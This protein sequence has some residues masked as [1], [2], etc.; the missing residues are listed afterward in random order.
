MES[1]QTVS[2]KQTSVIGNTTHL[3]YRPLA[4]D[5]IER[6]FT[7]LRDEGFH[8]TSFY[9]S[10]EHDRYEDFE[11]FG[12]K[13][14]HELLNARPWERLYGNWSARGTHEGAEL[15]VSG[16]GHDL[17][18]GVSIGHGSTDTAHVDPLVRAFEGAFAPKGATNGGDTL[19]SERR[20]TPASTAKR[21]RLVVA[22]TPYARSMRTYEATYLAPDGTAREGTLSLHPKVCVFNATGEQPGHPTARVDNPQLALTDEG[23][24]EVRTG[25]VTHRFQLSKYEREKLGKQWRS[26]AAQALQTKVRT[27]AAERTLAESI[28]SGSWPGMR[29]PFF[30]AHATSQ[31]DRSAV[32]DLIAFERNLGTIVFQPLPWKD[33]A[34]LIDQRKASL[35]VHIP[36]PGE[37]DT[38]YQETAGCIIIWH[39]EHSVGFF[40]DSEHFE[41]Q[42]GA[43]TYISDPTSEIIRAAT[44]VE[45]ADLKDHGSHRW[46]LKDP[47][48]MEGIFL[49]ERKA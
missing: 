48:G 22:D 19:A 16:H 24:L 1:G 10:E 36:W 14:M 47:F 9:L 13:T 39:E 17:S 8:L 46:Y 42:E 28:T 33:R 34:V 12:C 29:H 6:L 41:R 4:D 18:D 15:W 37:D 2:F 31:T 40:D 20:A 45:K 25:T 38:E 30:E 32:L 44:P 5:S 26:A 49:L 27:T 23:L 11:T 35:R 43:L 7:L 3:F 21:T